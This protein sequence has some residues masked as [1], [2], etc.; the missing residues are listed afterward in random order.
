LKRSGKS[1]NQAVDRESGQWTKLENDDAS[2]QSIFR[3][4]TLCCN[5]HRFL[6]KCVTQNW[7]SHDISSVDF[8][9]AQIFSS[10]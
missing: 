3:A 2:P 10:R 7:I 6:E 9:A 1:V 5:S 4:D 8:F